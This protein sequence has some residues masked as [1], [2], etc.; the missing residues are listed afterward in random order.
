MKRLAHFLLVLLF[1]MIVAY[2]KPIVFQNEVKDKSERPTTTVVQSHQKFVQGKLPA[3]GMANYIGVSTQ[4]LIKQYGEPKTRHR[5]NDTDQWWF[6]GATHRD[7]FQ[8]YVRN[9]QVESIFVL[10]DELGL[11][12]FEVGQTLNEV[13]EISTIYSNFSFV[14]NN[15]TYV[16]ELSEKDMNYQPLMA[17]DNN[18]FVILHMS[19]DTGEVVGLRY[20]S[21]QML[22]EL[23]P[24]QLLEGNLVIRPA[25]QTST[26]ESDE[27]N[28]QQLLAII[29]IVRSRLNL[30]PLSRVQETDEVA[31]RLLKEFIERPEAYLEDSRI[32]DK[33]IAQQFDTYDH[34]FYLKK[35][36]LQQLF[37]K[38]SLEETTGVLY[39]P[40]HDIPYMV[41]NWYSDLLHL[42][43]I[44]R[45]EKAF[46]GIDFEEDTI[47]LLLMNH[48]MR[49]TSET[50]TNEK[51]ER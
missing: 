30:A 16:M 13:S 22:L 31:E 42:L 2:T 8:V 10:G 37:K 48:E 43:P 24:Y 18:V 9:N 27:Q 20:L 7:Y 23:Q 17:F 35:E 15:Q 29:N 32:E 33:Q 21:Q 39:S 28:R 41:M 36:E 47:L 44:N 6:Y 34:A 40:T 14:F 51:D 26:P 19:K 45:S 5:Q 11:A 1:L 25:E 4:E 50:L 3:T 38:E 49:K 46:V 12:P